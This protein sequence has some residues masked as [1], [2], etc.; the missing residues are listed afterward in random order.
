MTADKA[1]KH[2]T[3]ALAHRLDISYT[4]AHR[5][6]SAP[7]A[8]GLPR[9]FV[10]A[11][12]SAKGGAGKTTLALN[13]AAHAARYGIASLPGTGTSPRVL[14]IDAAL[15]QGDVG[16]FLGRISPTVADAV[17]DDTVDVDLLED[18]IADVPSLGL[19]VLLAPATRATA[20]PVLFTGRVYRDIVAACA[21]RFDVVV[22][23]CPTAEWYHDLFR[24]FVLPVADRTAV[25]DDGHP[26]QPP[27][28]ERVARDGHLRRRRPDPR[29]TARTDREPSRGR[30]RPPRR[31][32]PVASARPGPRDPAARRTRPGP[33]GGA[34]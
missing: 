33:G 23:D 6:T 10:F 28:R 14:L 34:R 32:G 2:A 4:A 29:R 15:Q 1:R 24:S 8:P 3:R 31:H 13:L 19:S 18:A 26:T 7:D 25:V 17:R 22:V 11:V 12:T 21:G 20:S 27:E 5:L 30:H 16:T 9:P